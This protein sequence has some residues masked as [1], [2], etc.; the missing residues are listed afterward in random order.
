MFKPRAFRGKKACVLGFG[1]SGKECAKLLRRAGF[2]VFIS[3]ERKLSPLQKPAGVKWESGGHTDK[4]FDCA[5]VVKSPGM[6]S[7]HPLLKKLAARKI[8]VFS[9]LEV[10]L[11]YVPKSCKIFAITGTNGKT[12]TTALL[13]EILKQE[14]KLEGR[15]RKVFTAG[16]IGVPLSAL[17]AKISAGS[18][19]VLETSSYQLEDSTY[20]KPNYAAILNITPDHVEHHGS[21]KK[22]CAAIFII[23]AAGI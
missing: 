15:G 7:A 20:F 22:Y 8:P 2:E 12:T 13:S 4:V 18:F 1:I 19:I 5:F 11:A 9:E 16:N 23:I 17:A 6:P 14:C 10:A 21:L 3:E